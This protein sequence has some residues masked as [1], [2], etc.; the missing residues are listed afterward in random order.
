MARK[1][2]IGSSNARRIKNLYIGASNVSRR[3]KA[4]YIGVNGQARKFWPEPV[5]V[6]NYYTIAYTYNTSF[7]YMDNYSTV[8]GSSDFYYSRQ[9]SL[10]NGKFV[11]SQD[12]IQYDRYDPFD[13]NSGSYYITSLDGSEYSSA[14]YYFRS[15]VCNAGSYDNIYKLNTGR[16]AG[17]FY[18][19][20]GEIKITGQ[21]PETY[22]GQVRSSIRN[23]YPDNG[24]L[25]NYWYIYQ[26]QT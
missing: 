4:A 16:S 22:L 21:S 7:G 19:A 23:S 6:W 3:I 13:L 11:I 10:S 26:G 20:Q 12:D 14:G 8:V 9:Y 24:I 18:V 15:T 2:Y 17:Y 1:I 25:G 5:H